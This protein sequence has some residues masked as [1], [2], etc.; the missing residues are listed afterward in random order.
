MQMGRFYSSLMDLATQLTDLDESIHATI[1]HQFVTFETLDLEWPVI[2]IPT[3]IEAAKDLF[4]TGNGHLQKA[5]ESFVIDGYVTEHLE[6]KRDLS[7]LLRLLVYFETN[8]GRV[9]AMLEKRL[10]L[11]EPYVTEINA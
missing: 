2:S 7:E 4:R 6:L 5:M 11:L 3:E 8:Q 9:Y 1:A 10:E